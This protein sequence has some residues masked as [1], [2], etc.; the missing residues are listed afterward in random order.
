MLIFP[1]CTYVEYMSEKNLGLKK[2]KLSL[3]E[4]NDSRSMALSYNI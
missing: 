1:K 3:K 4:K 2:R